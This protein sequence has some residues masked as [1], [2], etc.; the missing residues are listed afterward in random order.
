MCR[1]FPP[2]AGWNQRAGTARIRWSDSRVFNRGRGSIAFLLGFVHEE[3]FEIIALCAGLTYRL[4]L[5]TACVLAVT[6]GIV[7]LTMALIAGY[8]HYEQRAERYA[9]YLPVVSA[10]VLV[11]MDI[12][13]VTGLLQVG[14][15]WGA[16]GS[17]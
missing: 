12:G 13:F 10:V 11:T 8:Q 15:P 9:P 6:A 4:E 2:S 3:E 16:L 17:R 5:M 7:A 1:R 14:R